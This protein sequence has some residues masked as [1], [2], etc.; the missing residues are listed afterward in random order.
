MIFKVG[1]VTLTSNLKLNSLIKL[2][3]N[4]QYFKLFSVVD[5][6]NS[7]PM[8]LYREFEYAY[9]L[10]LL[11]SK[12][13]YSIEIQSYSKPTELSTSIIPIMPSIT[14]EDIEN[15]T[16]ISIGKQ[17]YL[18]GILRPLN[19]NICSPKGS[20]S[21]NLKFT[22]IIVPS[23]NLKNSINFWSLLG[24]RLFDSDQN[25]AYLKFKALPPFVQNELGLI[26]NLTPK[27]NINWNY[28]QVGFT[29]ISFVSSNIEE[30]FL[31]LE[32]NGLNPTKTQTETLDGKKIELFF[33]S[34][35][36]GEIVEIYS[37]KQ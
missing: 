21:S 9:D 5:K 11:S 2:F 19:A 25:F 32:K 30:D 26:I 33:I 8:S 13:S 31:Y 12:D 16:E 6:K 36:D 37:V 29:S 23:S 27:T 7:T 10:A 34:G 1:H 3:E 18:F 28:D 24:F 22:D 35:P 17:K 4:S 20:N 14:S 15:K